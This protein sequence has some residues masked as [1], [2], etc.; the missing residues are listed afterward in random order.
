MA[1][2][3]VAGRASDEVR[4]RKVEDP[5]GDAWHAAARSRWVGFMDAA[6]GDA[7]R[8][9]AAWATDPEPLPDFDAKR[10]PHVTRH[11]LGRFVQQRST[12]V[13]HDLYNATDACDVDAIPDPTYFHFWSEVTADATVDTLCDLCI[14]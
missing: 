8:A 14:P 10:S 2:S 5:D 12:G 11:A 1:R 7:R 6:E 4:A 9:E 13:V 3:E